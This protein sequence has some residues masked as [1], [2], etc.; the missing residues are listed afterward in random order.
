MNLR[1]AIIVS[2]LLLFVTAPAWGDSMKF[3]PRNSPNAI[4]FLDNSPKTGHSDLFFLSGFNKDNGN[5]YGFFKSKQG[6]FKLYNPGGQSDAPAQD[7]TATPEPAS[8]ALLLVGMLGIGAF[9]M[10]RNVSF[11]AAQ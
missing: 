3:K 11:V 5:H 4:H 1:S 9:A 6:R 7:P 10:R 2:A 8:L